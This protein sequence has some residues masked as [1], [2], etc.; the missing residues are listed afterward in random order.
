MSI[1]TENGTATS[2][3]WGISQ[4]SKQLARGIMRYDTATHGGYHLTQSRVNQLPPS[5]RAIIPFAGNGWYEE[6]CDWCIVA[7]AFPALFSQY[8]DI[9]EIALATLKHY[10][11]KAYANYV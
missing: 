2:T 1:Y 9:Q 5:L 10:H 4:H 8:P 6:D 11:P 3:P 7:L